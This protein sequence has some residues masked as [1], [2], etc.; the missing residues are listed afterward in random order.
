LI[1]DASH[2]YHDNTISDIQTGPEGYFQCVQ[3]TVV[4][5]EYSLARRNIQVTE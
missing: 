3:V 5:E 2:T 4:F 1:L